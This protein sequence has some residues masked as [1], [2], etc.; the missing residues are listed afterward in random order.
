MSGVLFLAI[1]YGATCQT[2]ARMHSG[3]CLAGR[4]AIENMPMTS[5]NSASS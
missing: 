2:S 5:K 3:T 1:T 4:E